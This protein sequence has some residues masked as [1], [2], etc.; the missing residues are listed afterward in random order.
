MGDGGAGRLDAGG[1]QQLEEAA[2]LVLA[3]ALALHLG[4][5][6]QRRE[7]VARVLAAHA[8]QVLGVLDQVERR[9]VGVVE[10]AE[11]RVAERD[12]DARQAR[13]LEPVALGDAEHVADH[14]QGERLGDVGGEVARPVLA[15]GVDDGGRPPADAL[16]ELRDVARR[17]RG[18]DDAAQAG[19]ARRIHVEHAAVDLSDLDGELEQLGAE[20][21]EE[22]LRAAAGSSHVSV[23]EH[24]PV[25]ASA[26][27]PGRRRLLLPAHG[28][29]AAQSRERLL[30]V[31]A[32]PELR[33]GKAF[34]ARPRWVLTR[35]TH[36]FIISG[37][38]ARAQ[39]R[40]QGLHTP[41]REDM[42]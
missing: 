4:L 32:E 34:R 11:L 6:E 21:G 20:A 13:E 17:E 42:S 7:V 19:V 27:R 16:L 1:D 37:S 3:Q 24:R 25:A 10:R 29:L 39:R 38:W 33:L 5:H 14:R 41:D 36:K 8:L 18:A 15:D 23:P 2:G 26:R 22:G 40:R 30:A 9:L 35:K 31:V 12:R 28:M